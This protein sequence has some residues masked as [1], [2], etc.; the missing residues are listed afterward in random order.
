MIGKFALAWFFSKNR[1]K[2]LS[3]RVARPIR[4]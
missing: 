4:N 3:E 1:N 2:S